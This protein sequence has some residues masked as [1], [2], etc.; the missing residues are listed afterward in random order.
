MAAAS[1][2]TLVTSDLRTMP[3][4][5]ADFIKDRDSP[6]L[7]LTPRTASIREAIEGLLVLWLSWS[8]EEIRNQIRWLP[9]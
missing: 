4:H 1:G 8:A 7:I 9:R 5:F 6:G 2:R 3:A